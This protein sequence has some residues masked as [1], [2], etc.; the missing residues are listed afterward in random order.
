MRAKV[1]RN[2][3]I[4]EAVNRGL[5]YGEVAEQFGL[6]RNTIAGVISRARKAGA[7]V[8]RADCANA[9]RQSALKAAREIAAERRL[10]KRLQRAAK[11]KGDQPLA[12]DER[13]YPPLPIPFAALQPHHCRF[14]HDGVTYCGAPI[15]H[16]AHAGQPGQFAYCEKHMKTIRAKTT[17]MS[18]EDLIA[19]YAP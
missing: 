4:I 17:P 14:T 16:G 6:T 3:N 13:S 7:E 1:D 5:S 2:R 9:P 12:R 18:I 8:R 11:R 19:S 10:E 15:A